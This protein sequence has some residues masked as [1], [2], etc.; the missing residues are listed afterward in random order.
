M[1]DFVKKIVGS[2][3]RVLLY[4]GD[5]DII[6]DFIT[7]QKFSERL[8]LR[9]LEEKKAWLV[10]AQIGGFKTVYDGLIFTTIRGAGHLV[11]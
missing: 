1:S 3:V 8:G 7:G 5:T 2:N 4:Y 9:Q 11:C 6:C 10:D